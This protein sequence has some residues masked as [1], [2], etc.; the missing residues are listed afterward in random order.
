[1]SWR[2][3]LTVR[4]GAQLPALEV[5]AVNFGAE[6]RGKSQRKVLTRISVFH[7]TPLFYYSSSL[8][9]QLSPVDCISTLI[10]AH[11]DPH[12]LVDTAHLHQ[13]RGQDRVFGLD[14]LKVLL[15]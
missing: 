9:K 3:P 11:L 6:Q 2:N 5:V 8:G 7:S 1:M 15:S 10:K 13:S 14:C 12:S 4:F